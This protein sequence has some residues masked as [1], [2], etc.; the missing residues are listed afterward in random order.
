MGDITIRTGDVSATIAA[1]EKIK[2]NVDGATRDATQ[3]TGE[4]LQSAARANF[5]GV[6]GPGYWH[7]GGDSPNT[8]S[9]HLQGSI[10]FLN[11][12]IGGGGYYSTKIGPTAIYSRVI[13]LGARISHK[14]ASILAWF[15]AQSGHLT[16]KYAV[17]IPPYP[18]F[19]PASRDLPPK[20]HAIF[21]TAWSGAISG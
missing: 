2:K 18:Y 19:I 8:V 7:G 21:A 13:E 16:T 3:R 15:D 6:H 9:G 14:E 4:A 17:T 20:M 12:V 1:L 10:I 5:H 11:P